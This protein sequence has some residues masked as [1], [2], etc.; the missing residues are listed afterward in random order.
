LVGIL[1]LHVAG[2]TLE[3]KDPL[4][5]ALDGKSASPRI[6]IFLDLSHSK[7]KKAGDTLEFCPDCGQLQPLV[8]PFMSSDRLILL[9]PAESI[10]PTRFATCDLGGRESEYA[11]GVVAVRDWTPEK[12]I[13]LVARELGLPIESLPASSIPAQ[14]PNAR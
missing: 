8:G 9:V 14:S 10:S 13:P 11:G 12:G 4:K 6:I 2:D 3:F 5:E 1:T 7:R